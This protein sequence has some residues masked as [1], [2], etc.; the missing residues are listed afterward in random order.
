LIDLEAHGLLPQTRPRDPGGPGTIAALLDDALERTPDRLA[1]VG[2][3][4]RFTVEE[5]DVAARRV[6][7]ERRRHRHRIWAPCASAP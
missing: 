6:A 3:H 2:R 7:A 1:L 4:G 5:L